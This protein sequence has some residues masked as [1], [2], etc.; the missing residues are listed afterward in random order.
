LKA[1]RTLEERRGTMSTTEIDLVME[2]AEFAYMADAYGEPA[3]REIARF[4]L[5]Q[6]HT[7]REAAAIMLSKHLRWADDLEGRGNGKR[8]DSAAFKRYYEHA[9]ETFSDYVTN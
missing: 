1:A 2:D 8:A 4:L 9:V 5:K 3:L 6:G 7:T